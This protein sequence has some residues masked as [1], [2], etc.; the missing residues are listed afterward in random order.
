MNK[1][2]VG[3]FVKLLAGVAGLIACSYALSAGPNPFQGNEFPVWYATQTTQQQ[4]ISNA[5]EVV[6]FQ[7]AVPINVLGNSGFMRLT[8]FGG[9]PDAVAATVT[10]ALKVYLGG[11]NTPVGNSW[12][13]GG[14]TGTVPVSTN[15]FTT[16]VSQPIMSFLLPT[17]NNTN[18]FWGSTTTNSLVAGDTRRLVA[19]GLQTN[20]VFL[21]ITGS[22]GGTAGSTN[23]VNLD[24]VII[25]ALGK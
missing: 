6:L 10:H 16:T 2:V 8:M 20:G 21:T 13:V 1:K 19:A 4:A 14:I 11:T 15:T 24:G 3:S 12:P 5:N 7:T 9:S 18:Y 17:V 22:A 25:E 23:I